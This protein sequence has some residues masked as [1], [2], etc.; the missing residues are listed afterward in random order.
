M[1]SA[2]ASCRY[3]PVGF[4]WVGILN[5]IHEPPTFYSIECN[6]V[7]TFIIATTGARLRL[8]CAGS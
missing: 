7:A 5:L 3:S 6:P 2:P 1:A 4:R 8:S